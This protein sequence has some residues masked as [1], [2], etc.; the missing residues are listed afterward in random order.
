MSD[1][2]WSDQPECKMDHIQTRLTAEIACA[3]KPILFPEA[4]AWGDLF[5]GGKRLSDGWSEKGASTARHAC[6][7]CA[8]SETETIL[9]TSSTASPSY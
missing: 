9:Y 4:R 1:R 3:S 2:K 5:I 7:G 8:A 6:R